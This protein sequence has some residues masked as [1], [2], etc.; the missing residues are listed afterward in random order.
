LRLE[1]DLQLLAMELPLENLLEKCREQ[2]AADGL[3]GIRRYFGLSP[4]KVADL[5]LR[6]AANRACREAG[7]TAWSEADYAVGVE[8]FNR[9]IEELTGIAVEPR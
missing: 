5:A 3:A 4:Y 9:V 1:D 8:A 6:E 7:R 2:R